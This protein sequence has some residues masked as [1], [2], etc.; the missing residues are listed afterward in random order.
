MYSELQCVDIT[1]TTYALSKGNRQATWQSGAP[2]GVAPARVA[3]LIQGHPKQATQSI[4]HNS[5]RNFALLRALAGCSFSDQAEWPVLFR[6]PARV[7][8]MRFSLPTPAGCLNQRD[9]PSNK[10]F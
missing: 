5:A 2:D 10:F 1:R 4:S 9:L 7:A 6:T 8:L 3:A